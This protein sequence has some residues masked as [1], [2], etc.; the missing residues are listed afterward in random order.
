MKSRSGFF[1][2][3]IFILLILPKFK[4]T[5]FKIDLKLSLSFVLGIII[6]LLS[7]SW[8]VSKD[9]S[10]DEDINQELKFAIT[11]RYS[12]INDNKYEEEILEL[13]LFYF[14]HGRIFFY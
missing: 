5:D 13:K 14:E 6:F 7:T 3:V 1:S 4:K 11:S 10:I 12:T 8:V 9:V 2:L